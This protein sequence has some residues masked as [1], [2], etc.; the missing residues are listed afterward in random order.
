MAPG[1][2]VLARLQQAWEGAGVH[3]SRCVV[4][5]PYAQLRALAQRLWQHAHPQGF[6]PRFES[7]LSWA[8]SLGGSVGAAPQWQGQVALD[9]WS[10][11][12]LLAQAGQG[13]RVQALAPALLEAAQPLVAVVRAQPPAR[14]ADWVAQAR[15]GLGPL[16]A[17]GVGAWEMLV[18]HVALEW[19]GASSFATDVLFG[20][21]PWQ[22]AE[23]VLQLD[24]LEADP[25]AQALQAHWGGQRWQRLGAPG[26]G[27]LSEGCADADAQGERPASVFGSGSLLQAPLA[28]Q[29]WFAHRC[30]SAFDEAQ[31][32][33][34]CAVRHVQ[35][36]RYPLALVC[37]DR[38]L[39]RQ[40]RAQLDAAGV[41]VRDETGWKLSTSAAAAALVALLRAAAPDASSDAVL[42]WLG[43]SALG[44]QRARNLAET[45]LRRAGLRGWEAGV[46]V[47][48]RHDDEEVR[49]WVEQVQGL[50]ALLQG[51]H[52]WEGWRTRTRQALQGCGLWQR[53]QAGLELA[54][55]SG[56]QQALCPEGGGALGLARRPIQAEQQ[57]F[58]PEGPSLVQAL[59]LGE[60]AAPAPQEG[61]A[62]RCSLA[63]FSA[64]VQQVLEATSWREPYPAQ[65]HVVLLPMSQMLARPFA[66][67]VLAGC[68]EQRLA[69]APSPTGFWSPAQRAA[70]GLPAREA[71][72]QAQV[73]AWACAR[74]HPWGDVLWRAHDD[75]GE[76]LLASALVLADGA[77]QAAPDGVLAARTLPA[78]PTAAP[79]PRAPQWLPGQWSASAYEDLRTCPYRFFALRMLRLQG[80][81]ELDEDLDKRDFGTWLHAVLRA[82]HD[83]AVALEPQALRAAL[84]AAAEQQRQALLGD[85]PEF[86]PFEAAWPAVREAYLHWWLAHAQAGHTVQATEQWREQD[87]AGGRLVGQL[88]RLDR[89]GDGALLVLD[90]KTESITRTRERVANALEDTQMAFYGA[91]VQDDGGARNAPVR[92]AYLHLAEGQCQLVEQPALDEAVQALRAGLEQ[93]WERLHAGAPL[94]ALGEGSACEHCAARGLCRKD[95]WSAGAA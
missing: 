77:L 93:D 43:G 41:A 35:A 20:P 17:A 85:D 18:T 83:Q 70:L 24:G 28:G 61:A 75:G 72:A 3:P 22:Q 92:G 48:A 25:L 68:D 84:D 89:S 88:D 69:A 53:L 1:V 65:E 80:Q 73:Q 59:W 64:W 50:R 49:V 57:A 12:Q 30:T 91:L 63:E 33:A 38:A 13:Q 9:W 44:A 95:F 86:L 11:Q 26:S 90:Y 27:P 23:L 6:M 54:P 87:W 62:R 47:L 51:R 52:G 82:F 81:D 71:L 5:L 76:P 66:A 7:T 34:A 74:A 36:G 15:A 56:Q 58:W 37:S 60:D 8:A 31:R 67:V 79:Q 19:L 40:V 94:R 55:G 29:G 42:Q 78:Q 14:R 10:A 16:D 39:A 45:A 46:R 32:A 2:G 21:A 4:L